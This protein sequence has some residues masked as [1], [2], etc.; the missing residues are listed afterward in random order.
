MPKYIEKCKNFNE[1]TFE[2]V[3]SFAKEKYGE[4]NYIHRFYS[5][6]GSYGWHP[7]GNEHKE[8]A[9]FSTRTDRG[10]VYY[11]GGITNE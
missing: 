4:G 1:S 2:E 6:D 10:Y 3:D 8:L 5:M 11:E 7:I 9:F